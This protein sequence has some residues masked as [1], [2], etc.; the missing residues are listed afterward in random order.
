MSSIEILDGLPKLHISRI[1]NGTSIQLTFS[2]N[3]LRGEDELQISATTSIAGASILA[4]SLMKAG[5]TISLDQEAEIK[6]EV[7]AE[8][9]GEQWM[10]T[11]QGGDRQGNIAITISEAEAM[12]WGKLLWLTCD[13]PETHA[14]LLTDQVL[15]EYKLSA[16]LVKEP[17]P[18]VQ[19]R[20]A[21][22]V[23]WQGPP[24]QF[25]I[26]SDA[27]SLGEHQEVTLANSEGTMIVRGRHI[28]CELLTVDLHLWISDNDVDD[29]RSQIQGVLVGVQSQ[30]ARRSSA[31]GKQ[32]SPATSASGAVPVDQLLKG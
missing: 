26:L 4:L 14:N 13:L 22:E 9:E 30:K 15:G 10:A 27:L 19:L 8:E 3:P 12:I 6:W 28:G 29:L 11:I 1:G 7:V 5:D 32:A 17:R 31:G 21:G 24:A 25:E 20:S 16:Q 23:L 2:G 18:I